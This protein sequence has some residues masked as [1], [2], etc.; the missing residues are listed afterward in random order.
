MR[1]DALQNA[2]ASLSAIEDYRA[3]AGKADVFGLSCH[4]GNPDA[5]VFDAETT[6]GCFDLRSDSVLVDMGCGEGTLLA[7]AAEIVTRGRLTG[8]VP[9]PE[10][11][12]T[13]RLHLENPRIEIRQGFADATGLPSGCADFI[14]CNNV[15]LLVPQPELAL[16]EIARIG[17]PGA[18]IHIGAQPFVDEFASH[19][20]KNSIPHVLLSAVKNGGISSAAKVLA[21]I[22]RELLHGRFRY[23][24]RGKVFWITPPEFAKMAKRHSL[25]VVNSARQARRTRESTIVESE[26]RMRYVLRRV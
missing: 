20:F 16:T 24:G 19:R 21:F 22:V 17:K 3:R 9:T 18:T 4:E 10:E 15:L 7:R 12:S 13:V 6:L 26:T 11:V 2:L 8:I 25:T 5:S 1:D 23:L 14:V